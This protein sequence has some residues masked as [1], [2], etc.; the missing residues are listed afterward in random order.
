[1]ITLSTFEIYFMWKEI[2][3]VIKKTESLKKEIKANRDINKALKKAVLWKER[4][5]NLAVACIEVLSPHCTCS[6][7]YKDRELKDPKCE[8]CDIGQFIIPLIA[9]FL[10]PTK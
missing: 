9:E 3:S 5:D 4:F 6:V 1:M 8:Y 7:E 10:N 2:E